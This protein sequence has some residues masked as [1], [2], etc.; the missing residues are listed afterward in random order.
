MGSKQDAGANGF[1]QDQRV[2]GTHAVFAEDLFE[3]V[4][5]QANQHITALSRLGG[6]RTF[7]T[8]AV[9]RPQRFIFYRLFGP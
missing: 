3:V 9:I 5:D 1:G 8:L 7:G 6:C 4:V 2:T